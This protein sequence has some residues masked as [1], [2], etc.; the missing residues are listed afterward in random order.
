MRTFNS[1]SCHAEPFD[2]AQDRL[3]EASAILVEISCGEEKKS[4]LQD[5][6][7]DIVPTNPVE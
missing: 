1:Q 7:I 3:R 4:F 2:F 6:F 5:F